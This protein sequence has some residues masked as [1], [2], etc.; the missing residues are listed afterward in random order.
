VRQTFWYRVE[1]TRLH[2]DRTARTSQNTHAT[3]NRAFV[4]QR[5][6]GVAELG[7]DYFIVRAPKNNTSKRRAYA[8]S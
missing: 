3:G 2:E 8:M 7:Y 4:Q 6:A 5:F 1:Y